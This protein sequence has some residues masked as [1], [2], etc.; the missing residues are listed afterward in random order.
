MSLRP[1]GSPTRACQ[2]EPCCEVRIE[3]RHRRG[4]LSRYRVANGLS[5]FVSVE[6]AVALIRTQQRKHGLPSPRMFAA[7]AGIRSASYWK[8][9]AGR[10]GKVTVDVMRRLM[11]LPN[12]HEVAPRR[13]PPGGT[14]LRLQALAVAGYGVWDITHGLGGKH[15]ASHV[16]A[17]VLRD[18]AEKI[19]AFTDEV[20][21]QPGPRPHASKLARTHGWKAWDEFDQ[22]LFWDL[23]WD[24]QGGELKP[25]EGAELLEEYDFLRSTGVGHME[26]IERLGAKPDT[27]GAALRRRRQ[28]QEGS[29]VEVHEGHEEHEGAA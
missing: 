12:L 1:D 9:M 8:I 24:G 19:L 22:E 25:L 28:R 21:R 4:K 20:V 26:A 11:E 29:A 3:Q 5:A 2:C 27:V 7:A 6:E 14:R 17:F 16:G 10:Q 23:S 13:L 15:P 18:T